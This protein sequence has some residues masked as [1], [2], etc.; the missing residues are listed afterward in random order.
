MASNVPRVDSGTDLSLVPASQGRT[1][2]TTYFINSR[3]SSSVVL[4]RAIGPLNS[5]GCPCAKHSS[6]NFTHLYG[7]PCLEENNTDSCNCLPCICE[8]AAPRK[9][10]PMKTAGRLTVP[11]ATPAT[12]VPAP[13]A[14][15]PFATAPTATTPIATAPT[16]N[17][18]TTSSSPSLFNIST[19]APAPTLFP[20]SPGGDSESTYSLSDLPGLETQN[21]PSS[22]SLNES[23]LDLYPLDNSVS[24]HFSP[25]T[26][27]AYMRVRNYLIENAVLR[28]NGLEASSLNSHTST[29]PPLLAQPSSSITLLNPRSDSPSSAEQLPRIPQPSS[30]IVVLNPRPD[31]PS[32]ATQLSRNLQYLR[33]VGHISD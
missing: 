30:S 26:I 1:S 25:L 28:A 9:D 2:L 32:S 18:P 7:C 20:P 17:A 21:A 22:M 23:E 16:A 5:C 31:S 27:L 3:L 6:G 10:F 11:S 4:R 24:L 29:A 33:D 12:P 13:T 8:C 15:A 19:P 14:T